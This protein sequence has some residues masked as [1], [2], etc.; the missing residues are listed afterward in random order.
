MCALILVVHGIFQPYTQKRVNVV[1]S[2]YLYILCITA[3][4]QILQES[5][6][7]TDIVCS[8]LLI[9][10]TLHAVA[11]TVYKAVGFF[12]RR[13]QCPKRCIERRNYGSVAQTAIDR[14]VDEE[15]KMRKDIFD[16]I[17]TESE[18]SESFSNYS[19]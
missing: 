14:S 5:D 15:Q 12:K 11:L 2:L 19:E 6:S 9:A 8:V 4:M 18:D 7:T 1:E 13:F 3:I 17:F 16:K 10:T